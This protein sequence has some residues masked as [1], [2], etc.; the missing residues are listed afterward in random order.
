MWKTRNKNEWC[1]AIPNTMN[2][3]YIREKMSDTSSYILY[4]SMF[5]NFKI[6]QLINVDWNKGS[7]RLV[8]MR[9]HE[10]GTL[11]CWSC[12]VSPSGWWLTGVFTVR[13]LSICMLITCALVWMYILL[14]KKCSNIK[15]DKKKLW[16]QSGLLNLSSISPLYLSFIYH[17]S[18]YHLLSIHLSIIYLFIYKFI[19]AS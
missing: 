16:I 13:K 10:S 17:P 1:V 2:E 6:S 19:L 11:A 15:T 8:T 12:S 7:R 3:S 4:E 9:G 14:Q 18:I 5:I